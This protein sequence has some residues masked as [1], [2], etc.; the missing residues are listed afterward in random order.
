MD[1]RLT[2]TAD[3]TR[4]GVGVGEL[5]RRVAQGSLVRVRRGVFRRAGDLPSATAHRLLIDATLGDL[6][7]GAVI[8][9]ASAGILHG[10]PVPVSALGRVSVS[11]ARRGRGHVTRGVRDRGCPVPESDVIEIE[12]MPVTSLAR[13]VVDL[14]RDLSFDWGVAVADYALRAGLAREVLA[15]QVERSRRWPGNARARAVVSFADAR[16]ESPGESRSRAL[17]AQAGLPAPTL[18]FEVWADGVLL[19]RADFAWEDHGVLG[20]FD[21]LAKYGALLRPGETPA[22]ALAREKVREDG[23]RGAGWLV[24]RWVWKELSNP[25]LLGKKVGRALELGARGGGRARGPRGR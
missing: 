1:D 9:H 15:V 7:A 12:G 20:E 13:T 4:V 6:G 23:F 11:H 18:Q 22:D 24:T 25:D 2:T 3:L 16:A 14:G 8:S 17:L 10:L 5:R 21:G 19:G